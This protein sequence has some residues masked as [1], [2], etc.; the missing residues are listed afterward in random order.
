VATVRDS[1]ASLTDENGGK[2]FDEFIACFPIGI[3]HNQLSRALMLTL[4]VDED[5]KAAFI[6]RMKN[7]H[8]LEM[9]DDDLIEGRHRRYRLVDALEF[10][11]VLSLTRAYIPPTVAVDFV[12][13]FRTYL[14]EHWK[15]LRTGEAYPIQLRLSVDSL[16]VAGKPDR[17][18]G[19][20]SRGGRNLE[21]VRL[22]PRPAMHAHVTSAPTLDI[23]PHE[24][25]SNLIAN[26]GLAGVDTGEIKDALAALPDRVT[27]S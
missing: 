16:A 12:I 23:H 11:L 24:I 20:G 15:C 26:L 21:T 17:T 9:F 5:R 8:T 10:A 19:R 2:V 6:A 7:I 25:G 27:K 14:D 18:D 13:D 4:G 1:H 3:T 22:I